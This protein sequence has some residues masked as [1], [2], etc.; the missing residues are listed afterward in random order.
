MFFY[1]SLTFGMAD[2]ICQFS[3]LVKQQELFRGGGH[4]AGGGRSGT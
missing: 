3:V 1:S 2:N 4:V